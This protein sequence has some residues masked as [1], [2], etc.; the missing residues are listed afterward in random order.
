MQV[1]WCIQQQR[2]ELVGVWV[3]ETLS[4]TLTCGSAAALE[5]GDDLQP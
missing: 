1:L 3:P 5:A 4:M 2:L